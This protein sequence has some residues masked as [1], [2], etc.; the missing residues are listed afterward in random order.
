MAAKVHLDVSPRKQMLAR[1]SF[2]AAA[3]Q[4]N[5]V[6]HLHSNLPVITGD[7]FIFAQHFT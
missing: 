4:P 5:E 3:F 1:V 7:D 2:T 6:P